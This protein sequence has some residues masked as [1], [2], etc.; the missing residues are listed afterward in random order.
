MSL[1]L[2]LF[3]A[4]NGDFL[5]PQKHTHTRAHTHQPVNNNNT[6]NKPQTLVIYQRI[7]WKGIE[8][9]KKKVYLERVK[10]TS[11]GQLERTDM[12]YT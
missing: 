9:D 6:Q 7:R 5:L 10:N 8:S 4:L 3:N 1:L 11:H 2:T 12:A